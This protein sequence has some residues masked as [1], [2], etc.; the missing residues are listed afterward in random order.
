VP[1]QEGRRDLRVETT[2]EG[3]GAATAQPGLAGLAPPLR[4][5]DVTNARRR[6]LRPHKTVSRPISQ[7]AAVGAGNRLV[8]LL[9]QT[10]GV[11]WASTLNSRR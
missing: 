7:S 8:T 2:G 11:H 3:K 1:W 5:V 6:R 10:P 9:G 4:A